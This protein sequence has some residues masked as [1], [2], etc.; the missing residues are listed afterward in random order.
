MESARRGKLIDSLLKIAAIATVADVVPLVGENRVIVKRG[1][2]GL[3]R[4]TNPGLRELLN[5]SEIYEGSVPSVR[6]IA[7]GVAPR[8][9]AAGRMASASDVVELFTT[10]DAARARAIA[11]QLHGLNADR[12]Q[13]Q[14]DISRAIVEQCSAQPVTDADTALVFAGEGWHRGVVGIAASKVVERF[15]RPVFVLGTENGVAHGSGRSIRQFH[16]LEA[17]ESMP[18]LFTK[19]G[20]HRQ[21]AGITMPSARIGEFRERLNR[22]AGVR[23]S[24]ADFEPELAIDT[25]FSLLETNDQSVAE[26][27][28]LSPFGFGNPPPVLLAREVE[29]AAPPDIRNGKHIFLRLRSQGRMWF[30]KA[31]NLAD[32]AAELASGARIDVAVQFEEDA[33][34]AAR[35][36]PP[37]QMVVRDFRRSG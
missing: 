3:R 6:D 15:H 26:I 30:A 23:L 17:L 29:V 12:R 32:R 37:W 20:G 33:Y 13:T 18:D 19:F 21:A 36:Y 31:W 10:K 5:I 7:F 1:L 25:E 35:G 22:Y 28:S 16:L 4:V 14:D 27:L 9:N 34:S 24:P 11:A 8:I 2:E